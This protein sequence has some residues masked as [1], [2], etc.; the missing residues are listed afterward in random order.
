MVRN[1][2]LEFQLPLLLSFLALLL[3]REPPSPQVLPYPL[4]IRIALPTWF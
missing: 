1:C 2:Q 4:P 3:G